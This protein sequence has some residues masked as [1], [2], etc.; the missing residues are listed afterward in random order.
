MTQQVE[1]HSWSA[2]FHA[3]EFKLAMSVAIRLRQSASRAKNELAE[4]MRFGFGEPE[5][6]APQ[7]E[8]HRHNSL[9]TD[10]SLQ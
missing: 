4:W 8:A 1:A 9:L 3:D 10:L 5:Q 2:H 6:S 7:G